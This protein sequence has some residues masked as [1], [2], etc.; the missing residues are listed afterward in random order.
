MHRLRPNRRTQVASFPMHRVHWSLCRVWSVKSMKMNK[1]TYSRKCCPCRNRGGALALDRCLGCLAHASVVLPVQGPQTDL[2]CFLQL[3]TLSCLPHLLR[4]S[5]LARF[6]SPARLFA[7]CCSRRLR[8]AVF[9]RN[10]SPHDSQGTDKW[11]SSRTEA[12][13]CHA[14]VSDDTT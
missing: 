9:G 3:R 10:D 12:V 4:L 2:R 13:V 11:A 6:L 1:S 5:L 7:A 8:S 14:V